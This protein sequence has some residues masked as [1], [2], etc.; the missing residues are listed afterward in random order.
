MKKKFLLGLGL[1]ASGL[2]TPLIAANC[3]GNTP[4]QNT[5]KLTPTQIQLIENSF[6]FEKTT[7]G[8]TKSFDELWDILVNKFNYYSKINLAHIK[9]DP[10]L[11]KLVHIDFVDINNIQVGHNLNITLTQSQSTKQIYLKWQ[12]SCEAFGIEGTGKVVLE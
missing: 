5:Q 3:Q 7:E 2:I 11:K 9:N 12:V 4:K 1:V 6:V 8:N 10:E